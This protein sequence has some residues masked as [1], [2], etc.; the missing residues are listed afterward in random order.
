MKEKESV[1][2]N[3][4]DGDRDLRYV[5]N[6]HCVA[7]VSGVDEGTVVRLQD[8]EERRTYIPLQNVIRLLKEA[9]AKEWQLRP[10]SRP[11]RLAK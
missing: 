4:G 3:L 2:V 11:L 7:A 6:P 10:P 5:V 1:F 8:G 9:G